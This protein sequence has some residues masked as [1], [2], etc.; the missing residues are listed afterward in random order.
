MLS[1]S[2]EGL[3]RAHYLSSSEDTAACVMFLPREAH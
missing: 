3:Y 1:S 2:D